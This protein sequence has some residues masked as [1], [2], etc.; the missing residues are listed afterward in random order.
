[1]LAIKIGTLILY[2]ILGYVAISFPLTLAA[3]ASLGLL[4]LLVLAHLVECYLYRDLIRKTP[5]SAI[6]HL[7][8]VFLFGVF[9]MMVMKDAVQERD[10]VVA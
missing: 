3:N 2:L 6:W 9:H 7:L 1:M 10:T 4:V 8:N 5:G